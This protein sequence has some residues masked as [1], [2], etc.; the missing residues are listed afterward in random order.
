MPVWRV[1][2]L[3]VVLCAKAG[4]MLSASKAAMVK[5]ERRRFPI[6]FRTNSFFIFSVFHF[7]GGFSAKHEVS[8][9]DFLK[10]FVHF[11]NKVK[12]SFGHNESP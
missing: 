8:I 5:S 10:H 12:K 9:S 2:E 1:V 3:K 6:C 7:Y 4:R 11:L